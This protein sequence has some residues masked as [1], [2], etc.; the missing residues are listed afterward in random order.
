[1]RE[2]DKGD[3]GYLL[4]GHGLELF[5][6]DSTVGELAEST[7]LLEFSSVNIS[8]PHQISILLREDKRG[9]DGWMMDKGIDTYHY[10]ST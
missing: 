6:F 9:I 2:K 10:D 5:E 1:M 4:S 7:L 8:L 3:M